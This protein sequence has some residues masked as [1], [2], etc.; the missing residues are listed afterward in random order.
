MISEL[1]LPPILTSE[2]FLEPAHATF[3]FG[4]GGNFLSTLMGDAARIGH[5]MLL[6]RHN[7]IRFGG[8]R[9]KAGFLRIFRRDLKERDSA[10]LYKL[11]DE[12]YASEPLFDHKHST[13]VLDPLLNPEDSLCSKRMTRCVIEDKQ[14]RIRVNNSDHWYQRDDTEGVWYDLNP[15]GY[16]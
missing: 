7:P 3:V 13:F 5:R 6:I 9:T 8:V 12:W 15:L 16:L 4:D 2:F 10:I 1:E 14:N 11:P